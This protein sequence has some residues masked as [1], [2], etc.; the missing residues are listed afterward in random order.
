MGTV[1]LPSRLSVL[2]FAA[3]CCTCPAVIWYPYSRQSQVLQQPVYSGQ[4]ALNVRHTSPCRVSRDLAPIP[5]WEFLELHSTSTQNLS[6][7]ESFLALHSLKQSYQTVPERAGWIP[8]LVEIR[9]LVCAT[10]ST[11]IFVS[12]S[13][14]STFHRRGLANISTS[15]C[16]RCAG[17]L[18]R[19]VSIP[20]QPQ[21]SH[22]VCVRE[23][24]N[25]RDHQ[26]QAPF[27]RQSLSD[28]LLCE[29]LLSSH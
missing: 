20:L 2:Q 6:I 12:N 28:I 27:A 24:A 1:D 16:C 7:S 4:A 9:T 25:V 26:D 18:S 13:I 3:R 11:P 14:R 23:L 15:G 29:F 17:S 21:V 10:S 5:C 8:T 22:L 19:R